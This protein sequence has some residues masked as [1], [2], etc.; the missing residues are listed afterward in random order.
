MDQLE[1]NLTKITEQL[2][3]LTTAVAGMAVPHAGGNSENVRQ[4][5]SPNRLGDDTPAFDDDM[6]EYAAGRVSGSQA[7]LQK[8][9]DQVESVT[10]KMRG[11]NEDLLDYDTLTFE[12]QLPA[13]FKMPDMAKFNGNGDP[14][15]HLRQ[16][17][18]SLYQS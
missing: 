7:E 4:E 12:E 2:Q 5:E 18:D 16:F 10:R 3:A 9:R 1:N 17:S 8:L 13:Q 15:V 6:A 14:R 11:K